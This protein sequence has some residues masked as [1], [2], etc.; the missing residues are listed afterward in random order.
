MEIPPDEEGKERDRETVKQKAFEH[1][2]SLGK[3]NV[4]LN[5]LS[6]VLFGDEKCIADHVEKSELVLNPEF[7]P[8]PKE[9]SRLITIALVQ[10]SDRIRLVFP[11]RYK[12]NKIK[13]DDKNP[14]CII[15]ESKALA[16]ELRSDRGGS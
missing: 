15:I 2:H 16:D 6:Q 10:N 5:S 1:I 3:G 9:L 14:N 7:R 11:S 8:N 13:L 12:G 4:N